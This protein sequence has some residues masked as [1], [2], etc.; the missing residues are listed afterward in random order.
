[1][2]NI[3]KTK[4]YICKASYFD[5]NKW[6]KYIIPKCVFSSKHS[7]CKI[8]RWLNVLYMFEEEQPDI[9]KRLGDREDLWK[10]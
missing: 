4:T 8:Y 9:M 5:R 2:K 10:K 1:M 6:Y 7:Y 3:K